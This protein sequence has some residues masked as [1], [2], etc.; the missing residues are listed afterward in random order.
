M[1]RFL[2]GTWVRDY[3]AY[4]LCFL[5]LVFSAYSYF[6]RNN[7]FSSYFSRNNNLNIVDKG[8]FSH[9]GVSA[10]MPL[11]IYTSEHCSYCKAL[12]SDLDKL[13]VKYKDISQQKDSAQFAVLKASDLAVVP[14][15]FIADTRIVGYNEQ[16]LRQ[17]LIE[18][19][20]IPSP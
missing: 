14:V 3:G 8:D 11:V 17:T 18:K 7:N 12:K 9:F 13:K 10:Q 16:L 4:L 2:F 1:R 5:L 20:F 19:G 6:S 15:I